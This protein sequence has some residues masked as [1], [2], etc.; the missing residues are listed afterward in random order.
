[1]TLT[2]IKDGTGTGRAAKVDDHGRLYVSANIVTHEQ[3][4]A[5]YHENLFMID[6]S[7]TL[8]DTGEHNM[9]FYKQCDV[10]HRIYVGI[11]YTE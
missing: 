11:N 7:V 9:L 8:P 3:H 2:V 1:M 10:W 6:A 5:S 4:H